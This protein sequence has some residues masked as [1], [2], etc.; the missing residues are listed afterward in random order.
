MPS[1]K[2]TRHANFLTVGL[3]SASIA[4]ADQRP[5]DYQHGPVWPESRYGAQAVVTSTGTGSASRLR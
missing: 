1:N 5:H 2:F 4:V 3:V